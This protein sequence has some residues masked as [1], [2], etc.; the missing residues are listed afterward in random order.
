MPDRH[1]E[2]A[3]TLAGSSEESNKT[4]S[5]TVN[6]PL[7]GQRVAPPARS[8]PIGAGAAWP[9]RI[10]QTVNPT[11]AA[12][13]STSNHARSIRRRC[14]RIVAVPYTFVDADKVERQGVSYR[15]NAQAKVGAMVLPS[16]EISTKRT[17][18]STLSKRAS[19]PT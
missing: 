5:P 14:T 15:P 3:K 8:M 6:N 4:Y 17:T 10:C 18:W 12:T 1:R 11:C 2:N 13:R 7:P 19:A 9:V 16:A